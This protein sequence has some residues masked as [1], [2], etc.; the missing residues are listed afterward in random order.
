[1]VMIL[2]TQ[3]LSRRTLLR[4][5]TA[6]MALPF[7]E[8]MA[9][10][11][12]V[13]APL[14]T[15]FVYIPNG[16]EQE[17]WH[18]AETGADYRLSPTLE[19]LAGMK[20]KCAVL[21][22]LDRTKVPGTDGHAQCGSCWLSSA[23]PNELS[24]AGYP[25]KRTLDQTI[26]R[27]AGKHTA[28][29]SL[30]LSCNPFKDNKE[31]IYFDAIS[32]YGH[33]HVARSMRDPQRIFNRLF[34]VEEQKAHSSIL[35]VVMGDAKSLRGKLGRLDA[36]KLDEY[37]DSVRVVEMQI[38]RVEARQQELARMD[39]K[40]PP[41]ALALERDAY[42]QVIADLMI[43]AFRTDMT[44]VA[45]MMIGP[46]RWSTAYP[47]PGVWAKAQDHHNLT[48][49]Q[50]NPAVKE[51]L[52]KLDYF[53]LRQYAHLIEKM[54]RVEEINGKSLLDNSL[55]VL[56]SGLSSGKLHEQTN[57]PTVIAGGGGRIKSNRHRRYGKGTPVSNLW[58]SIARMHGVKIE[59][60][61]DSTGPLEDFHA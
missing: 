32:W 9:G 58:L 31:S 3:R 19:P 55:V 38:Q 28:F 45:T 41:L 53:H 48:H 36:H 61:G 43:L 2:K 24:P 40:I 12:S 39:L 46:E 15:A 56:G 23:R 30:E 8:I 26:A 44:R 22:Q 37:M 52:R 1:M 49:A 17:A 10:P 59:R 14:R 20:H 42:I 13:S 18:P 47:L 35:D 51:N 7:M 29:R 5:A 27:E 60:H 54:D 16:V 21:T 57:L 34:A 50:D 6:S 33:G 11:K 4:G 25:L